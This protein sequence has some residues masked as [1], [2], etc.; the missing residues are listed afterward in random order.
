MLQTALLPRDHT[1]ATTLML[2]TVSPDAAAKVSTVNTL[3][4]AQM[5]T[6]ARKELKVRRPAARAEAGGQKPWQKHR[7]RQ[8]PSGEQEAPVEKS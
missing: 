4:Y 7:S 3:R 2:A 5:L 1:G 6:G 8:T